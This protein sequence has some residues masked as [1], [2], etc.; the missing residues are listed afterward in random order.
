M[1]NYFLN[2]Y[3]DLYPE[4]ILNKGPYFYFTIGTAAYA[5]IKMERGGDERHQ[6]DM[7]YQ[8]IKQF[9][10]PIHEIV[11]NREQQW[12][13]QINGTP[14][15]LFKIL[16][17][18]ER[19]VSNNDVFYFQD[20]VKRVDI[21]YMKNQ[22]G[23]LWS[24]KIDYMEHQIEEL[25]NRFPLL[26]E[27]SAY[28]IGLSEN[29]ISYV[30]ATLHD[31]KEPMNSS[32]IQHKRISVNHSL[33]DIYNPL[34]CMID[35]KTRDASEYIKSLFFHQYDAWEYIEKFCEKEFLT[36]YDARML[37]GRLLLPTYYFDLYDQ[38]I[39]NA[40]EE[41]KVLDFVTKTGLYEQFLREVF[42]YLS[43]LHPLPPVLWLNKKTSS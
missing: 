27:S 28:Y 24:N 31:N 23:N 15:I 32:R 35:H 30:N 4:T 26:Y 20:L 37:F 12:I 39:N 25:K 34:N 18:A 14:Y 22:W 29:A 13:S 42:V 33:F 17:D 21:P 40:V 9:Q 8:H 3:Y 41:K 38:I 11:W 1:V 19:R 43:R 10:I 2:Y 16:I 5:L 6:L 36:S 7:L